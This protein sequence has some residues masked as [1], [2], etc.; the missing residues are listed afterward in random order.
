MCVCT[1][2]VRTTHRPRWAITTWLLAARQ[3]EAPALPP[4]AALSSV[5]LSN[6]ALAAALAVATSSTACAGAKARAAATVDA[7]DGTSSNHINHNTIDDK[8]FVALLS[9]NLQLKTPSLVTKGNGGTASE[10]PALLPPHEQPPLP[11]QTRANAPTVASGPA[12]GL[13]GVP[14]PAEGQVVEA[15]TAG[16][17]GGV[18]VAGAVGRVGAAPRIFVSVASYRDPECPHTLLSLFSKAARPERLVVGVCFQCGGSDAG[19]EGGAGAERGGEAEG[20]GGDDS[21]CVD[22]SLLRAEW[23]Q[24]VHHVMPHLRY[25]VPHATQVAQRAAI[26]AGGAMQFTTQCSH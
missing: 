11:K 20:G 2:K 14:A 13:A 22:L 5:A 26:V 19:A 1:Y 7:S 12:S 10:L 21:A 3:A 15:G 8:H 18:G 23:C 25:V 17:A 24:Q 16:T 4:A 9:K 6:A